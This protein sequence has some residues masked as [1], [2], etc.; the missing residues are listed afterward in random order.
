MFTF[1]SGS[2][3]TQPSSQSLP[4]LFSAKLGPPLCRLAL[5]SCPVQD[6]E[7]LSCSNPLG[8]ETALFL[9]PPHSVPGLESGERPEIASCPAGTFEHPPSLRTVSHCPCPLPALWPQA[10]CLLGP[11]LCLRITNLLGS[12]CRSPA[13]SRHPFSSLGGAPTLYPAPLSTSAWTP[14]LFLHPLPPNVHAS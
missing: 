1:F 13:A 11:H 7:P 9:A 5:T 10:H 14:P 4:G 3:Q 2:H 12:V 8:Q 6:I